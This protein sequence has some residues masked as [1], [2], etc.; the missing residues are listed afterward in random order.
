MFKTKQHK[1]YRVSS[2]RT[3]GHSYGDATVPTPQGAS[4][5]Q[6]EQGQAITESNQA[7]Q[8]CPEINIE[9]II[10]QSLQ[11]LGTSIVGSQSLYQSTLSNQLDL[12]TLSK[13]ITS[14]C[15]SLPLL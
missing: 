15:V 12:H 2:L 14:V 6:T 10:W 7:Q 4:A 11:C 1:V 3:T 13:P 5:A 9:N 8:S